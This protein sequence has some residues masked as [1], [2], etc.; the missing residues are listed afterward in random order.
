[1]H[2]AKQME[3]ALIYKHIISICSVVC[4]FPLLHFVQANMCEIMCTN[5]QYVQRT[6]STTI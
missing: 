6:F 5:I 2:V 3:L 4:L 1:M